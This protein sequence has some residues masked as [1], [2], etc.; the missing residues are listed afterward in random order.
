MSTGNGL[1]NPYRKD[2]PILRDSEVVYFDNAATTQR[3]QC[4]MEAMER[5][6]DTCNAN[7]LRGLYG[8]SIEATEEYE[9]AR[10]K[11]AALI[12]A[13]EDG[14]VIFTRNTT[15]SLNLVAYSYGLSHVGK[16]DEIVIS[17][18]EH[19][20]NI[21]PWQM[22]CRQKGAKLIYMEPAL[23]GTLSEEEI[24]SKITDRTKIVSIGYVSNVLG[25]TNPVKRIAEEAHRR[26]AVCVVD[27][28]QST[29][30]IPVNV[31][32]IGCD[33]YAFSGHKLM[34]PMGIGCLYGRM[35]LLNEMPPFLTGGEM[36][37]YVDR[38]SA[39]YAEVPEKFEAGTVNASGAVGLGAAI[40]Y[41]QQVG[42]DT[43]GKTEEALTAKLM[44]GLSEIPG[45]TMYGAAEPSKHN[46]I[47]TFNIEGCHP[48]DVASVL[49][50]EHI[51]VRAGH[52]CAQPLMKFLGANA[53]V[54]ASLYFY[55]T[56]EEV[57][58][59]VKAVSKVRSWLGY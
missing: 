24:C 17:V 10:H 4:V 56:E 33:F 21:L 8:W 44:A 28:A 40:D 43:I 54:R 29:P 55:N 27:G 46:G 6:N 48:H 26:G 30:H 45:V 1:G 57:D 38:Q 41:L 42:F 23:D 36:I 5:F 13:G 14:E 25:V 59:F 52:H 39:T 20:S 9:K 49:D 3:P 18:M 35:E 53:T 7:P 12:G 31:Q 58:R 34:A 15:E 47:V 37:E 32:E 16:D 11:A 51:A 2:F 50:T 22:V 19:H